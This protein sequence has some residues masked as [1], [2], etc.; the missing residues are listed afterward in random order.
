MP[1]CGEPQN[2]F[3]SCWGIRR[4][5]SSRFSN[6]HIY[7]N[8]SCPEEV[9]Y[10]P[11]ERSRKVANRISWRVLIARLASNAKHAIEEDVVN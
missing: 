1:G 6:V 8:Y 3:C 9:R 11:E 4:V 2:A 7:Q 10:L 5:S